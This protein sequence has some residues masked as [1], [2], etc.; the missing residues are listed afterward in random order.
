M[1][2]SITSC[3]PISTRCSE[4]VG[5]SAIA[6]RLVTMPVMSG[7]MREPDMM[8]RSW[9]MRAR[10]AGDSMPAMPCCARRRHSASLRPG[11]AAILAGTHA[12]RQRSRNRCDGSRSPRQSPHSYTG[13]RSAREQLYTDRERGRLTGPTGGRS[14]LAPSALGHFVPRPVRWAISCAHEGSDGPI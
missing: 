13:T 8:G 10:A 9:H 14:P 11:P 4:P 1:I 5:E 6:I 3:A 7:A 12:A 2:A